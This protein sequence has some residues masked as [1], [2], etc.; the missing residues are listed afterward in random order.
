MFLLFP[1]NETGEVAREDQTTTEN[2]VVSTLLQQRDVHSDPIS[3]M[4]KFYQINNIKNERMRCSQRGPDNTWVLK[5]DALLS[6]RSAYNSHNIIQVMVSVVHL[7]LT[8]EQAIASLSKEN[9]KD[10]DSYQ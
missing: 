8:D 4:E 2:L 6:E 5:G 1:S 9:R 7:I 10:H 3:Y